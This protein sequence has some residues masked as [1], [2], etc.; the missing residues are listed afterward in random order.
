VRSNEVAVL[1]RRVG[2][3][4]DEAE[5]AKRLAAFCDAAP[6]RERIYRFIAREQANFFVSALCRVCRV[7]RSAY[8]ACV[9]KQAE[10]PSDALVSEAHLAKR[11]YDI[12]SKSRR[13]YGSPRVTAALWKNQPNFTLNLL[14]IPPLLCK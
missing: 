11:I 14:G 7:S 2:K 4:E 13:R 12:W 9:N 5:N 6:E 1:R 10:G 8:Y 3:L